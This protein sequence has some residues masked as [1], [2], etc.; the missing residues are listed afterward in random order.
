MRALT[1][2]SALALLASCK[3][4]AP[5]DTGTGAP[6]LSEPPVLPTLRI[7]QPARAAFTGEGQVTL[8]GQATAGS[9]ALS[10]L[11]VGGEAIG[12]GAEGEFTQPWTPHPGLNRL[13]ARLEDAGGERAVD[14][15]AFI[16][17]P[18]HPPGAVLHEAVRLVLGP[19]LSQLSGLMADILSD[20]SIADSYE[21]V[22]ISTDYADITPTQITWSGAGVALTP[23]EG[24][25]LTEVVIH[26]LRMDFDAEY[27]WIETD[28]KATATTLTLRSALSLEVVDGSVSAQVSSVQAE[29]EDFY[30]EVDWLPDDLVTWWAEDYVTEALEEQVR[31]SFEELV[32]EYLNGLA[33]GFAF[34]EEQPLLVSLA[35]SS[36]AV[37][38]GGLR[39]G[40]DAGVAA[41]RPVPLSEGAGSIRTDAPPPDWEVGAGGNFRVMLD[42]DLVNQ[43]LFASW[44]AGQ[45]S[46]IELTTED[47]SAIGDEVG[48]PLGPVVGLSLDLALPPV[49]EPRTR[50]DMDLNLAI[51]EML[52]SFARADGAVH[53]FSVNAATGAKVAREGDAGEEQVLLVLDGRPSAV[54]IEVGV[55][56]HDPNLDPGD[57]AALVRMIIPPLLARS[58]DFLPTFTVP[59]VALDEFSDSGALVGVSLRLDDP[60]F[61]VTPEGWMLLKGR[62]VAE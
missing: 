46:Q 29:M 9:A 51:G 10:G 39:M 12:L 52:L 4:G 14:G 1:T 27:G 35:L 20:D 41:E 24:T 7:D 26:D 57:V 8:A 28:G 42:D 44:A 17:G 11:S 53:A 33:T 45:L 48:A 59:P 13:G 23:G 25:L 3:G 32:P 18:T 6:G 15:R 34:G 47:L 56:E 58:G 38:P 2:L 49:V 43:L 62:F 61:S 37:T 30:V 5:L 21:G 36:I 60:E 31:A 19:D 16:W 50:E 22:T 55:L 54:E 40:L